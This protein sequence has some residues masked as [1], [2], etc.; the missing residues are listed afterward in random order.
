MLNKA[1]AANPHAYRRL[2]IGFKD[3]HPDMA[4]TL[5]P[6]EFAQSY[7]VHQLQLGHTEDG[8][9]CV[10]KHNSLFFTQFRLGTHLEP[11]FPQEPRHSDVREILASHI[12]TDEFG[13]SGLDYQEGTW[14][15]AQGQAQ[16]GV[17][18]PVVEGLRTLQDAPVEAI[19]NP[20]EAVAIN[21]VRAWMG[22]WDSIKN[23]S[24]AFLLPD[25]TFIGG[26]YG[27]CFRDRV[28]DSAVPFGNEKVLRTFATEKNVQPVLDRICH[29]S[30]DDVH[31]MVDRIGRKNVS[32]WTPAQ[33]DYYSGFLIRNRD[34][35]RKDNPFL[36][37][38]TSAGKQPW[39]LRWEMAGFDGRYTFIAAGNLKDMVKVQGK[40]LIHQ[41][42][43]EVSEL[44]GRLTGWASQRIV[45]RESSAEA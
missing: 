13:L 37:Y 18:S 33:A 41:A 23:D 12:M 28:R 11:V 35:L 44:A 7:G 31:A 3:A 14:V 32:G 42:A 17:I 27:W 36:T 45:N 26:D 5:A 10:W 29:L 38:Q 22:D 19:R 6:D 25:G 30:D 20:D 39:P 15:D 16:K 43:S 1:A 8:Q 34:R 21:V 4:V 9:P 40:A 2:S 24:N